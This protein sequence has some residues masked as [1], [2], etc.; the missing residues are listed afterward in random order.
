M[1]TD[2]VPKLPRG[3]GIKLSGPLVFRI[4]ITALTLVAV[5]ALARPCGDAVGRFFNNFGSNAGSGSAASALPHPGTIEAPSSRVYNLGSAT[6]EDDVRR[7]VEGSAGS[8]H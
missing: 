1:S 8:A 2:E 7:I 6:T 3:R 4:A 5:I